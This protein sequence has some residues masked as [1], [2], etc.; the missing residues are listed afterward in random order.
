MKK[1]GTKD[2]ADTV[3]EKIIATIF[4]GALVIGW[5]LEET[6]KFLV[7]G[8]AEDDEFPKERTSKLM[9]R[10]RGKGR[11]KQGWVKPPEDK[12]I[13]EIEET[14]TPQARSPYLVIDRNVYHKIMHWVAKATG[15]ISGLGKVEMLPNGGFKVTSAMLL[16]QENSAASTELDAKA[17]GKAM[18]E[19]REA[20]GHLNF[21]WHSHV[22]MAAFWSDTDMTTIQEFAG[23]GGHEGF[24]LATVFNK[25]G[26]NQSAFC[27]NTKLGEMPMKF[28][29]DN[30]PMQVVTYFPK[31][32][33]EEWDKEYDKNCETKKTG[34]Y[35]AI[36]GGFDKELG[37][38]ITG[39][40]RQAMKSP[41][42]KE[43]GGLIGARERAPTKEETARG[44]VIRWSWIKDAFVKMA[45]N[46]KGEYYSMLFDE[47]ENIP[48]AYYKSG[49]L[50][51]W[52]MQP[53]GVPFDEEVEG[54]P[55]LRE[56]KPLALPKPITAKRQL[57]LIEKLKGLT[58]AEII[59][60]EQQGH[61]TEA[62]VDYLWDLPGM[63]ELWHDED[64]NAQYQ[65]E[66]IQ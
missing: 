41:H 21:W 5:I 25:R 35:S 63:Q 58:V 20:P 40:E 32:T 45:V 59:A 17:V 47:N 60:L 19:L 54:H 24:C 13:E 14:A 52:G 8:L 38:Y 26:E 4:I 23:A 53:F 48:L 50:V 51:P 44:W 62:E 27:L 33:F 6:W 28:L 46:P 18:Y 29:A 42:Y 61:L 64:N 2:W 36:D 22:D 10:G 65:G 37:R 7:Q 15:E 30:I 39:I 12:E 31:A 11:R 1:T 66:A 56:K 57:E 16:K 55:L 3:I 43:L 34:P 9:G 49:A